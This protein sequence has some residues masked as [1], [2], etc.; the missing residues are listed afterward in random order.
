MQKLSGLILLM[1]FSSLAHSE[2]WVASNFEGKSSTAFNNYKFED[3]RFSD[4]MRICFDGDRS[5]VSG[6]DL[7]LAQMAPSTLVGFTSTPDGLEVIN[8]Y[9]IDRANNKLLFTASRIGTKN[10]TSLL[11]DYAG[12]YVADVVK[13]D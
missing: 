11:P 9:Q 8:I 7:P 4:G 5:T 2:C 3:D 13:T 1:F 12:T 10:I 6:N